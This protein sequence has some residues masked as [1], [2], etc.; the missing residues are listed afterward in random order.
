[1]PNSTGSSAIAIKP[2]GKEDVPI[3]A[4]LQTVHSKKTYVKKVASFS[5]IYCHTVY[6]S[7]I[8]LLRIT[9]ANKFARSP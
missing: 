4:M 8:A 1:M 6:Q 5:S 3:A 2:K 9:S 7:P